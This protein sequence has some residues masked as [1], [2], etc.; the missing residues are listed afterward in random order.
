[1]FGH[2]DTTYIHVTH[3]YTQ[4]HK[5]AWWVYNVLHDLC[6]TNY[7]CDAYLPICVYTCASVIRGE[8][9]GSDLQVA[10]IAGCIRGPK[11]EVLYGHRR[12]RTGLGFYAIF[13]AEPL[14]RGGGTLEEHLPQASSKSAFVVPCFRQ[15]KLRSDQLSVCRLYNM[16]LF[17]PAV[18]RMF[19]DFPTLSVV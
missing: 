11:E 16:L 1:M 17:F 14:A 8:A 6:H 13:P 4:A 12:H 2:T 15:K 5:T 7:W 19:L 9:W 18:T 10:T 3:M